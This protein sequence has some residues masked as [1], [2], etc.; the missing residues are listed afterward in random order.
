M[1]PKEKPKPA[2][3]FDLEDEKKKRGRPG[4]KGML[5]VVPDGEQPA[6]WDAFLLDST[7]DYD[8]RDFYTRSVDKNGHYERKQIAFPQ[9]T[10]AIIMRMVKETE[11]YDS[12][13]GFIRDAIWHRLYQLTTVQ[14]QLRP[15]TRQLIEIRRR[16]NTIRSGF[17][18]T[19]EFKAIVIDTR[20]QVNEYIR[21]RDWDRLYILIENGVAMWEIMTGP[22]RDEMHAVLS[23]AREARDGAIRAGLWSWPES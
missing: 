19:Q 7:G 12:F 18:A 6:S 2:S 11:C 17:E 5:Q 15:E 10:T 20:E 8:P 4:G 23:T 13:D 9:G 16:A 3:V 14:N 22:E 1:A 21:E